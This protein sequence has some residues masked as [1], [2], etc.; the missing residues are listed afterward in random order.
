MYDGVIEA[1]FLTLHEAGS[2]RQRYAGDIYPEAVQL[3]K[4]GLVLLVQLVQLV[5]LVPGA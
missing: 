2:K 5:Q 4:G 1:Q 3:S